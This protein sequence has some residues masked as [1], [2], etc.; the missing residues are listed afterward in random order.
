L[1]EDT[2]ALA[3][4]PSDYLAEARGIRQIFANSDLTQDR[5]KYRRLRRRRKAQKVSFYFLT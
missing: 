4:V 2:L 5:E 1:Y 3:V